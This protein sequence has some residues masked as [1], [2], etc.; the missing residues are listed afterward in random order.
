MLLLQVDERARAV[1]R[2]PDV[3]GRNGTYV[4]FRKL[5]QRVA[6]FRQYLADNSSTPDEEELLAAIDTLRTSR[7]TAIGLAILA[8]IDA[9]AEINPNVNKLKANPDGSV[10]LHF[11]PKA[12]EGLESNWVQTVPGRAWFAYFRWY[13]PTKAY[14]DKSWALPD[15]ERVN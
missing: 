9:I 10:D 13:G 3:L 12:P 2:Q 4:V 5:H 1:R 11:G 15:I 6:A 14:Y 8:A 7:G